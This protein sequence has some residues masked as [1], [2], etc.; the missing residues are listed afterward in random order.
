MNL[1]KLETLLRWFGGMEAWMTL[2]VILHGIWR[3]TRRPAGRISGRRA[4]WLSSPAYY[5]LTTA[6]FLTLSAIFWK[7]LPMT[8][9]SEFRLLA[10]IVG[11]LFYFPGLAF[12]LWGRLTLAKMYFVSTAFGAQLFAKHQLVTRG[13]FALV[14]H[15]MYLGLIAS[16]VGSLFLYQT[17]TTVAFAIFAPFILFRSHREEQALAAEFGEEWLAYSR[18][19]P[20]FFPRFTKRK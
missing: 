13:P 5:L 2:G 17:W 3:G 7:P 18:C 19:V 10:L 15:P 12:L 1:E 9:T 8:L 11:V 6:L 16:S 4:G 20:P 14:R